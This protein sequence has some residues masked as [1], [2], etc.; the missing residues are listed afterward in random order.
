LQQQTQQLILQQQQQQQL[1]LQQHHAPLLQQQQ[2]QPQNLPQ[3]HP[4]NQQTQPQ[5]YPQQSPQPLQLITVITSTTPK[6]DFSSTIN[7]PSKTTT[8]LTPIKTTKF[9]SHQ[10][11]H[12]QQT[13]QP[14][15]TNP[16]QLFDLFYPHQIH[17]K[18]NKKYSNH[19]N[20][21]KKQKNFSFLILLILLNN[22]KKKI[23]PLIMRS[24]G[25]F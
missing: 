3:N 10:A 4:L 5:Q 16:A 1:S 12:Q 21:K 7:L 6:L 20:H 23:F 18:L 9:S 22:H 13:K 8:T 24:M 15:I 17:S 14:S 25:I 19:N 2:L 11:Q